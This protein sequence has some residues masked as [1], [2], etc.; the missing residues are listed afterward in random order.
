MAESKLERT[1]LSSEFS[2]MQPGDANAKSF[3]LSAGSTLTAR[4]TA[5][6]YGTNGIVGETA[7]VVT[8]GEPSEASNAGDAD[9]THLL[10]E[11]IRKKK[12]GE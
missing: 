3:S 10:T 1:F 2:Q 6:T 4:Q 7:T 12:Q 11:K 8:I 9:R 5:L